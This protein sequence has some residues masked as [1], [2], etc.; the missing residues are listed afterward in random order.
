MLPLKNRL[1]RKKDFD[2]AFKA[3]RASYDKIIGVK[4][5]KN[6]LGLIRFGIIAGAKVSKKAAERNKIKRRIRAIVQKKLTNFRSSQDFLIIALPSIINA[7]Y[8]E[9][10]SSL[11]RH[12]Q[13]LRV[14]KNVGAG[15][16]GPRGNKHE[17]TI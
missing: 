1:T 4:A 10:E 7:S 11:E 17:K 9:I 5:A 8:L 12:F 3:G 14:Y 6:N 13:N 2:R 15:P 16:Q